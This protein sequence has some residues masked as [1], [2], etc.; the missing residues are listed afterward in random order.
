MGLLGMLGKVPSHV[1]V[2]ASVAFAYVV[3][4]SRDFGT[5]KRQVVEIS[6]QQVICP[7]HACGAHGSQDFAHNQ[8]AA[9]KVLPYLCFGKAVAC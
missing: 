2:A 6:A 5:L 3:P 9:T 1:S 8:E 7:K 4:T